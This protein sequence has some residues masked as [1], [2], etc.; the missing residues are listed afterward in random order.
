[1]ITIRD[2]TMDDAPAVQRIYSGASVRFTH[3]RPFTAQEARARV[4]KALE[5]ARQIPRPRWD[6]GIVAGRDVVGVTAL[7]LRQPGLGTLSYI[8]R[9]D[10]WGKGYATEAAKQVV[11]FAFTTA[12]LER[13]EAKHH[14]ENPA[15]G[16]VLAK[17]GFQCVRTSNLHAIDGVMVPY[18]VYELRRS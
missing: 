17:A 9:E 15:S 12:D 7:R 1:M 3:D 18:P 13:L 6:F 5:V 11:E 16:R 4:A 8:L 10:T 2:L 14:P